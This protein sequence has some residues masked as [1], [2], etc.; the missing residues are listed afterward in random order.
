MIKVIS[1]TTIPAK[2]D[3]A[4]SSCA[5][6]RFIVEH[7]EAMSEIENTTEIFSVDIPHNILI[8]VLRQFLWADFLSGDA[9]RWHHGIYD[10]FRNKLRPRK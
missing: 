2:F 1:H 4:N 5:S 3:A 6:S 9:A 10:L 7:T 8:D